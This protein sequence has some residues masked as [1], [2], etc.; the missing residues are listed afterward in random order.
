MS[1]GEGGMKQYV[2]IYA[3]KIWMDKKKDTRKLREAVL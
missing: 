2:N 3:L 1:E